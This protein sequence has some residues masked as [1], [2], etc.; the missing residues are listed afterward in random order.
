[1]VATNIVLLVLA[2]IGSALFV[3]MCVFMYTLWVMIREATEYYQR[4]NARANAMI[5]VAA[6]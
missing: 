4:E 2:V 6:R 3:I 5:R 1:M